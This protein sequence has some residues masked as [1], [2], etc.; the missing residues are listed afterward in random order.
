MLDQLDFQLGGSWGHL[1][2]NLGGLGGILAAS[3]EVLGPFWLQVGGLW[4]VLGT[5][6]ED[7][8]QHVEVILGIM[9][10]NCRYS[11]NQQKQMNFMDFSMVLG[12]LGGPSWSQVGLSWGQVGPSWGQV[13]AR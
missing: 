13:G 12:V 7:F 3:W 10:K 9:L 5:M 2:A 6:L 8:G 1:G 11:K 4:G